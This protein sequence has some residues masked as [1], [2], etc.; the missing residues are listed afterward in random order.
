MMLRN[1]SELE[2]RALSRPGAETDDAAV[3]PRDRRN[4]SFAEIAA[5]LRQ[6]NNIAVL[7]HLRP[8]GDAFGSQLALG[9][10]LRQ[11]G[12]NVAIWN[13]D[14]LLEKYSFMPCGELL[15]RAPAEPQSFDLAV[16]LDTAVQNRLGRAGEAVR[17]QT[18]I[19]I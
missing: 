16:A 19:N 2:G 1:A 4:A 8:D 12:K 6:A 15:S 5:A 9:I 11:L 17:A 10:S 14:G 3:L 7:S 18:W 13:E